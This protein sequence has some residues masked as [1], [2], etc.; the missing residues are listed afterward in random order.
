MKEKRIEMEVQLIGISITPVGSIL[1]TNTA[2]SSYIISTLN[3]AK[4][5]IT[6]DEKSPEARLAVFAAVDAINQKFH[7][8]ETEL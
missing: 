8:H 4:I 2:S 3:T 6:L 5:C 7:D 1:V